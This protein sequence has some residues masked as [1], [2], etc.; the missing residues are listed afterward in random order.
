MNPDRNVVNKMGLFFLGALLNNI[1]L[2]VLVFVNRYGLK[3]TWCYYGIYQTGAYCF[4][5]CTQRLEQR[6]IGF[7]FASS[8]EDQIRDRFA[9]K[10]I[11][12]ET[13]TIKNEPSA[14]HVPLPALH[15]VINLPSDDDESPS[16]A[17]HANHVEPAE[18]EAVFVY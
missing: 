7:G 17:A 4:Q 13:P 10:K 18:A 1:G 8:A 16:S 14:S 3:I 6:G 12:T 15:G 9:P 11:K 2:L 5:P